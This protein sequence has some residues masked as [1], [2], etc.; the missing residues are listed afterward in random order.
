MIPSDL[1]TLTKQF[2]KPENSRLAPLPTST[3]NRVRAKSNGPETPKRSKYRKREKT[4]NYEKEPEVEQRA[5][6]GDKN[7][8]NMR[9]PC[10]LQQIQL[11]HPT[12]QKMWFRQGK[13]QD[14]K[15][16]ILD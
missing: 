3:A 4:I 11:R 8:K 10:D 14:A 7:P 6:I 1:K 15:T 16:E 12:T 5:K 2:P 13:H 9:L